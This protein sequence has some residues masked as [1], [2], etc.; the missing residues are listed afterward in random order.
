[1]LYLKRLGNVQISG[2]DIL[3]FRNESSRSDLIKENLWEYC[4]CIDS[5]LET[6]RSAGRTSPLEILVK[7]VPT[8]EELAERTQR[9]LNKGVYLWDGELKRDKTTVTVDFF[10]TFQCPKGR[11]FD[12]YPNPLIY[13]RDEEE[14]PAY[15]FLPALWTTYKP[16][17]VEEE[18][19]RGGLHLSGI[20]AYKHR[21]W[22]LWASKKREPDFSSL[23]S[24]EDVDISNYGVSGI[25][26]TGR[27]HQIR[28]KDFY[29]INLL[30]KA[31][32]NIK[33]SLPSLEEFAEDVLREAENLI[34]EKHG[35]PRIGEGWVSEM[36]LY[37][38]VKE[39]FP[40][41]QHHVIPAWLK[42]QELDVYVPSKKLGFE[43]QGIQHYEPLEFFGGKEALDR[44]RSLDER[45]KRQ[46]RSNGIVLIEWRFD[47]PID[48]ALFLQK[49]KAAKVEP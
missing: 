42:P 29:E 23:Q 48:R 33:R 27:T 31:P 18:I 49:I 37:N 47:E 22:R 9:W 11:L 24:L 10:G 28:N 45:K 38:L 3:A 20:E 34:R 4:S 13:H 40:D 30:R 41:A 2:R 39:V 8:L 43:Y 1:M 16:S 19:L 5:V 36:Q 32:W 21:R 25:R 12:R 15:V 46:C 26:Y 17:F 44:R 35:L 6:F 7:S 14:A